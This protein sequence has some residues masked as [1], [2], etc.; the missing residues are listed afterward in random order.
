MRAFW[1][2]G[3]RLGRASTT[4]AT[5]TLLRRRATQET[6][7]FYGAGA[8]PAASSSAP[9]YEV[10]ETSETQVPGYIHPKTKAPRDQ[11][12]M[13]KHISLVPKY[14]EEFEA[15]NAGPAEQ[16]D[17]NFPNPHAPLPPK[18][19][20]EKV[21]LVHP[22]RKDIEL[23]SYTLESSGIPMPIE[24]S[25][26]SRE[27]FTNSSPT[28]LHWSELVESLPKDAL[29]GERAD[30]SSILG[31]QQ[32]F[33]QVRFSGKDSLDAKHNWATP[34]AMV[35]AEERR[36]AVRAERVAGGTGA[37][38]ADVVAARANRDEEIAT[39]F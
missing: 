31:E 35:K 24:V 2:N 8:A 12:S 23:N 34:A 13:V 33:E 36:N 6:E 5:Q 22:G 30:I 37:D 29:F 4:N 10:P 20:N 15:S 25:E 28:H 1:S 3:V 9:T 18:N 39:I 7:A 26:G 32:L 38:A 21:F 17:I 27:D 14:A 16:S 19:A 11:E